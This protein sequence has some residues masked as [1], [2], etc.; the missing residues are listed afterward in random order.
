MP[1]SALLQQTGCGRHG[2][3]SSMLPAAWGTCFHGKSCRAALRSGSLGK[4]RQMFAC[5][6]EAVSQKTHKLVR[7]TPLRPSMGEHLPTEHASRRLAPRAVC[8]SCIPQTAKWLVVPAL[9]I[10]HFPLPCADVLGRHREQRAPVPAPGGSASPTA[11]ASARA[12]GACQL[13]CSFLQR[14][15]RGRTQGPAVSA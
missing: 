9:P 3:A 10:W 4:H 5:S 2:P 13:L 12:A 8:K 14:G 6:Y 7:L 1:G 15:S 11:C